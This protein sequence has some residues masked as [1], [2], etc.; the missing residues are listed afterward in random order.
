MHPVAGQDYTEF[1]NTEGRNFNFRLTDINLDTAQNFVFD[2]LP[3][4]TP[5]RGYASHRV[6]LV[7][8]LKDQPQ[9]GCLGPDL[10]ALG[11]LRNHR[12]SK[13]TSETL[14]RSSVKSMQL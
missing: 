9:V 7:L 5:V 11:I 3:F 1:C 12:S 6:T 14:W 2:P 10:Y 13:V 8:G 4:F